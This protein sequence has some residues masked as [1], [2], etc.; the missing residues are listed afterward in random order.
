M[1]I[2]VGLSIPNGNAKPAPCG[3][4]EKIVKNLE[5]DRFKERRVAAGV[6]KVNG[7]EKMLEVYASE[8]GDWTVLYTTRMGISCIMGTGHSLRL[9]TPLYG[10]PS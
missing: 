9:V 5:G 1:G 8:N 2:F 4:R 3:P 7:R 6:A 10:E